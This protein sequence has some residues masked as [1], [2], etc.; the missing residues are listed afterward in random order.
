MYSH[1][2]NVRHLFDTLF[3]TVYIYI[4]ICIVTLS[5]CDISSTHGHSLRHTVSHCVTTHIYMY[6]HSL[7]VRHLIHTLSVTQCAK[8]M[9][10][11]ACHTYKR[12]TVR[13]KETATERAS[14]LKEL[15]QNERQG[16]RERECVREMKRVTH[17]NESRYHLRASAR[18]E[19]KRERERERE[20]ERC[21][22]SHIQ[23][24]H[25][26]I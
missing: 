26:T 10:H 13:V 4:Y 6:G 8:E 22:A 16:E 2:L 11:I 25:G 14:C 20:R 12:I 21:H 1:S 19:R 23:T 15:L 9:S 7:N 3:H 18:R 24:N 17:M 5:V